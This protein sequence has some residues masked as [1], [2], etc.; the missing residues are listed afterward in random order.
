MR[1]N[2]N[3]SVRRTQ[4]QSRGKPSL[5]QQYEA[6]RGPAPKRSNP[7]PR[8]KGVI[9]AKII[10]SLAVVGA[11]AFG[12]YGYFHKQ[13]NSPKIGYVNASVLVQD[14]GFL[15]SARKDLSSSI[16][17]WN[18]EVEAKYA[19]LG[20]SME[21]LEV[22][23]AWVSDLTRQ[24]LEEEVSQKKQELELLVQK[25]EALTLDREFQLRSQI[26]A[27]MKSLVR[28]WGQK[29]GYDVLYTVPAENEVLVS[30]PSLDVTEK[31]RKD[32]GGA[33]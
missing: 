7:N 15:E 2:T 4:N 28:T 21:R 24:Q 27:Q 6:T 3:R 11:M 31:I 29:N 10:T 25:I 30:M 32:I 22:K 1:N 5:R 20:L 16:A 19:S 14:L 13:Q 26:S 33:L 23:K 17:K 18:Q 12:V 8:K 9:T